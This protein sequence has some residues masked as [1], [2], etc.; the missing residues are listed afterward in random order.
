MDFGILQFEAYFAP[1]LWGGSRLGALSG[2]PVTEEPIG[3]AWLISDHP[4]C[5]SVVSHGPRQGTS[6]RMLMDELGSTLLGSQAK[7][8]LNGRFPLLLKLID[9]QEVLSVQVHPDDDAA[10]ALGEKDG[11]KTEMWH[12]LEA[13]SG[14]RIT[15][16]L[17][18]GLSKE[19]LHQALQTGRC[20]ELLRSFAVSPGDSVFVPAGM[21]HAIGAGILLAEIQQNSD[22]TYRLHDWNR[23]DPDGKPR[24]LHVDQALEVTRF[25]GSGC[26][27]IAPLRC[28]EDSYERDYLC[29]CRFFATE[30]IRFH[31]DT[32][33][34]MSGSS[35]RIVLALDGPLHLADPF[36][37]SVLQPGEGALIPPWLPHWEAQGKGSF[38]CFYVPQFEEDIIQPLEAHG[39]SRE[40]IASLGAGDPAEAL[41]SCLR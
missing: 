13:A 18:P 22:I 20:A 37:S 3:E 9:A 27:R 4:Q 34:A 26:G 30:R 16:G 15:A 24:E 33:F 17:Q 6:L 1:R 31:G 32:V 2:T 41:A 14:S 38:L 40:Q 7:A 21:V 29:A 5:E 12:I 19:G 35:F 28:T 10:R 25:N 11:G 8:A 36:G 23:V 39:Y